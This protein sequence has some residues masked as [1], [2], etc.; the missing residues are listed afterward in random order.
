MLNAHLNANRDSVSQVGFVAL[1][2]TDCV[3]FSYLGHYQIM[4]I[5]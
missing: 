1:L 4:E 3:Y 2:N 5:F